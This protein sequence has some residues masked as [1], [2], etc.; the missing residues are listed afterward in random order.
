MAISS[1]HPHM[2]GKGNI[3][4]IFNASTTVLGAKK[5]AMKET[6]TILAPLELTTDTE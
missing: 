6:D 1:L 5:T 3:Y 2:A 4:T